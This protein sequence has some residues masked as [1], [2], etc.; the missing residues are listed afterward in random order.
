MLALS[1]GL[2]GLDLPL[3]DFPRLKSLRGLGISDSDI[4]A[5]RL[6]R[7]F[8][9]TNTFFHRE[10][11]LDLTAP[12]A[13]LPLHDFIICSDVLEHIPGDPTPAFQCLRSLLR[14]NG[15]MVFSVP[16]S[17]DEATRE[18]FDGG[19]CG[20]AD[21]D[22]RLVLVT[23]GEAGYRVYDNLVFHGGQGATLEHRLYS[24]ADLK[25]R[26]AASG[27]RKVE[28]ISQGN[29]EFGVRFGGPCSLPILAYPDN[30][31]L[32]RSATTEIV[33]E[34]SRLSQ[35]LASAANSRWVRLGRQLGLGPSLVEP[36]D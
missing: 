29:E 36:R 23:K 8:S 20:L 28:V 11:R 27:F 7:R 31:L 35:I 16:F 12:D 5:G 1:R 15:L 32:N 34:S 6:E 10:P 17:L 21:V 9:Y 19:N 25:R 22:G 33:S 2:F 24:E 4:Y 13:R 26:L 30:F 3:A 18:N 14:P